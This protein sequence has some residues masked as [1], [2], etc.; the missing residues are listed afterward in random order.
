MDYSLDIVPA[1]TEGGLSRA[2]LRV[3]L[4][5]SLCWIAPALLAA[6]NAWI[7]FKLGD[8]HALSLWQVLWEGGDWLLYATFTPFVFLF[9]HRYPLRRDRLAGRLTLHLL[10]ALFFCAAWAGSGTLLHW[11]LLQVQPTNRELLSWV[12][13]TLPFGVA[14][15]FCVL[16]VDHAVTYF[17]E[18]RARETQAA[19]LAAQLSKARLSA[20]R[21]QF[22]PHFLFNSLNAILVLVRDG[23]NT[24]AM[25]VIEQ[26]G[27]L[28]H[29]VM[30]S[31]TAHEVSL[32][33]EVQFLQRYLA[34]EQVRFSDRLRPVF[35]VDSSVCGAG[36]PAFILQP[37]VENA[38]R[39]GIA[40]HMEAGVV[41][42]N[43]RRDGN[44]LVLIISDD[45]PGLNLQ[46]LREGV[47]LENTRER[48]RTL[49]GGGA[50]LE[51]SPRLG[52]GVVATIRLPYHEAQPGVASV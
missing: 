15:Y 24:R 33:R 48:L 16:G 38:V 1:E 4:L 14:V 36:V 5:V 9:G 28:L 39:H 35:E 37:L 11:W 32:D 29:E 31:D 44:D 7:Q 13:T 41:Q 20:L 49:Y 18:A 52:G 40:Q 43:A 12:S 10:A 30:A 42:I 17:L 25:W 21:M 50:N 46:D 6:L 51:L 45:G 2:R 3:S 22:N 27:E 19:R 8:R 23:A 34:L 26:L 47:G